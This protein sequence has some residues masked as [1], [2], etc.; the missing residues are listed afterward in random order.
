M[1]NNV[2]V[3]Q[4]QDKIDGEWLPPL[5]RTTWRE[6][7]DNLSSVLFPIGDPD[8]KEMENIHN[9]SEE[10]I[11]YLQGFISFLRDAWRKRETAEFYVGREAEMKYWERIVT[12]LESGAAFISSTRESLSDGFWPRTNH[13]T[14]FKVFD[15]RHCSNVMPPAD[16]GND[17]LE[18]ELRDDELEG[19]TIFVGTHAERELEP[20]VPLRDILPKSFV[21]IRPDEKFER[22]VTGAF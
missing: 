6:D 19:D 4:Y 17:D 18:C 21:I 8:K 20:F 15:D 11:P 10:I 16:D 7:L 1:K 22:K 12:V 5:G 2:P 13:G 9:R 3:Y 14:G